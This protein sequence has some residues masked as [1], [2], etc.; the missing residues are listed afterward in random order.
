MVCDDY[1]K[2]IKLMNKG[3]FQSEIHRS[4]VKDY[5]PEAHIEGVI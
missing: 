4:E 5:H 3:V 2:K 1:V